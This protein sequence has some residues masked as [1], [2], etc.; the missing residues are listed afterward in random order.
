MQKKTFLHLTALALF[1]LVCFIYGNRVVKTCRFYFKIRPHLSAIKEVV[2]NTYNWGHLIISN[3]RTKYIFVND[4]EGSNQLFL[5]EG[6]GTATPLTNETFL[7]RPLS[8]SP[9]Q[10]RLL[11]HQENALEKGDLML[12]SF[13]N[14]E[15]INITQTP[16][17]NESPFACWGPEGKTIYYIKNAEGNFGNHYSFI[18]SI[19]LENRKRKLLNSSKTE[20]SYLVFDK[21]GRRLFFIENN[22]NIS[23]SSLFCKDTTTCYLK[24]KNNGTK[25]LRQ[26]PDGS[27]LLFAA[28]NSLNFR[29]IYEL[30][31][32]NG[33]IDQISNEDYDCYTPYYLS[34]EDISYL[35]FKN[36][37][38]QLRL[39][40]DSHREEI[41]FIHHISNYFPVIDTEKIFFAG[42]KNFGPKGLWCYDIS[43]NTVSNLLPSQKNVFSNAKISVP[44]N[45][46]IHS[47]DGLAIP[48]LIFHPTIKRNS[49]H[50]LV[51]YV[52]PPSFQFMNT[53]EPI[54]QAFTNLGYYFCAVNYRGCDGYGRKFKA[55]INKDPNAAV[56][57][58]LAAREYLLKKH[59]DIDPNRIILF[60][61]SGATSTLFKTFFS[62]P[63]LWN[64]AVALQVLV[65]DLSNLAIDYN[66]RYPP[67]LWVQGAFDVKRPKEVTLDRYNALKTIGL[68]V[69]LVF[70]PNSGHSIALKDRKMVMREILKFIMDQ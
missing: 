68:D 1:L 16:D 31:L 62:K 70:L 43:K 26:S 7:K 29:Q 5:M 49:I 53:W 56:E 61:V 69:N 51:L 32:I 3:D 10:K 37:R 47:F 12:Y 15:S 63:A 58:I 60:G 38:F 28:S 36:N 35:V 57:D 8:F 22:Q 30:N 24:L 66:T 39:L 18:Y 27:R 23:Y 46:I 34:N 6:D 2:L 54:S 19:N 13:F 9:D 44:E 17:E 48:L 41:D 20:K 52:S 42:L 64:R 14:K 4:V 45:H 59:T 67:M 25:W 21:L 33:Q 40:K 65:P 55:W 50:P 11:Y